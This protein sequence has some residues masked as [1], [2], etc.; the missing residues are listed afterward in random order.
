MFS[1]GD[2]SFVRVWDYSFLREPHQVY[3][4][5]AKNI[6]DVCYFNQ[7]LWTVG[8]EGVLVWSFKERGEKFVEPPVFQKEK[9]AAFIKNNQQSPSLMQ[10]RESKISESE[11]MG[12]DNLMLETIKE[13]GMDQ[14]ENKIVF[15]NLIK[16]TVDHEVGV[17]FVPQKV[18]SLFQG[19]NMNFKK[20]KKREGKP[21]L[22]VP[23]PSQ[24]VELGLPLKHFFQ[25]Q[26]GDNQF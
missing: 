6:N 14:T 15:S 16:K 7:K 19:K 12:E 25:E 10:E 4:G 11:N 22:T 24:N 3:I 5:H 1:V 26:L 2:D 23:V 9:K 21:K 8:S 17:K 20:T 13:K 18:D